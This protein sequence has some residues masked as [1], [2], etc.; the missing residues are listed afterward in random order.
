MHPCA[1]I[2]TVFTAWMFRFS[3]RPSGVAGQ[4]CFEQLPHLAGTAA[5]ASS[6]MQAEAA[7]FALGRAVR[8]VSDLDLL[9]FTHFHVDPQRRLCRAHQI[10]L[11]RR[12]EAAAAD[13]SGPD[14]SDFMPSTTEFVS[15]LYWRPRSLPLSPELLVPGEDADT[16]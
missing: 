4:A 10:V 2:V 15:D 13:F 6:L 7:R 9:L 12:M 5:L 3:V 16:G 8:R 14:G 11:V 1:Q